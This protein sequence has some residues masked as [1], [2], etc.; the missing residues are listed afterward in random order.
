MDKAPHDFIINHKD[1]DLK[2]FLNFKHRTFNSTDLLYFIYFLREH[3]RKFPSLEYAFLN[4]IDYSENVLKPI[5]SI[6]ELSDNTLVEYS[7][8]N[9]HRN[10][11]SL[12][13]FPT[14]TRKHVSTPL[15]KSACKRLNMYLRWMV[16]KDNEGVDFGIWKDISPKNLIC[17][18]DIHVQRVARDLKLLKRKQNDFE[19]AKELTNSLQKFDKEDPVRFDFALFGLGLE[20]K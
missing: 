6:Y 17:P 2:R 7:L 11:F 12:E 5:K 10:F 13:Y 14:R 4:Q 3:Y 8:V 20:R 9:F 18:L 1:N 15:K 16:R 19:S